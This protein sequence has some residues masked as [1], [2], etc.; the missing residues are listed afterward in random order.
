LVA[1]GITG[2]WTGSPFPEAATTLFTVAL[3]LW[4]VKAATLVGDG[5]KSFDQA[6]P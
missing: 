5:I 4:G 3:V 1:V 2:P 6:S